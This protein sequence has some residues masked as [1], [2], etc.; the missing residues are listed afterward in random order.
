MRKIILFLAIIGLFAAVAC[1]KGRPENTPEI[2]KMAKSVSGVIPSSMPGSENDTPDMVELGKKLY[3]DNR[4]SL[5]DTVSCN[6]CHLLEDKRAGVDNLPTSLGVHR[7]SGN[8]NSPTVLNAGFHIAQFWDGRAATLADQAKGPILNPVE[9]TMP[10]EKEVIAKLSAIPEYPEMFKRAFPGQKGAMTYDN[11]ANA[12]AA[13]ERTL[14]TKDRF[15]EFLMGRVEALTGDEIRGV[16]LFIQT[17]CTTCH[18]GPLLGGNSYQ[19]MGL[20]N[21]YSNTTDLGRYN[22]TK[23]EEDK[24]VF[25]VPSLR[26]VALTAPYFHD[27]KVATLEEAIKQMAHMQLGRELKDD[28]IRLIAAFLKS[29]S[30]ISR[31]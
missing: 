21:P 22:V 17:G 27:G 26:N 2:Q 15:D 3:F 19:K 23:K 9:M 12:I 16:E 29:L 18:N 13:F 4:L 8:R 5:D 1:K 28:E 31:Q 6:S 20:I 14:I 25:R 30:D 10:S 24:F 11:L 7:Q